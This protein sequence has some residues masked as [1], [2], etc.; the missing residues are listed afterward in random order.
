MRS[1][2]GDVVTIHLTATTDFSVDAVPLDWS[3]EQLL[4][5][6][7]EVIRYSNYSS[8][9][10]WLHGRAALHDCRAKN[11][12]Q[13]CVER[14]ALAVAF[15]GIECSSAVQ[16]TACSI[17]GQN[18]TSSEALLAGERSNVEQQTALSKRVGV[19]QHC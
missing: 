8:I 1:G 10:G 12:F 11:N 2:A 7:I 3:M 4:K 17:H 13:N 9:H 14:A 18:E 6:A 15:L 5:H 19:Q 16:R